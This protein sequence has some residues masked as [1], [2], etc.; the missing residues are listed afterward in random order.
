MAVQTVS[1][2]RDRP[3]GTLPLE[4]GDR[5][6]RGEFHRRYTARPDITKAELIEGSVHMRS[7]VRFYGHGRP[8]VAIL[9]WIGTYCVHT[10]GVDA[11]DNTTVRLDLEN[12]VQPDALL[13][14]EPRAGGRS[15]LSA[16]DYVEGA[17]ELIVE[18]AASSAAIDLHDKLRAYR[19]NGV[20]EYMVW[21]VLERQ[22]DWFVLTDDEYRP[23]TTDPAGILESR[24]FSGLRLAVDAL[25]QGD[26][27]RVL[28]ELQNGVRTPE[29]A[30][31]VERLRSAG[32]ALRH[33]QN[34]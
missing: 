14:I 31:F 28:S 6:T 23:L 7:P 5:L 33:P 10:P 16:D 8:H 22:L 19:R 25:L 9:T 17:P 12:E 18:I 21:R 26:L 27:A 11:A 3:A 34:R 2:T 4:N 30:A 20:Q 13:L 1:V 29:H 32:D 24:L 15:R